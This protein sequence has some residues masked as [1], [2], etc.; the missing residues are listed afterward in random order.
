[1]GD[2]MSRTRSHTRIVSFLGLGRK[3]KP[4]RYDPVV[5]ELAIDGPKVSTRP[6]PMHDAATLLACEG[7]AS[8][9][10]LGTDVVREVWLDTGDSHSKAEAE[11]LDALLHTPREALKDVALAFSTLP[12]DVSPDN[13]WDLFDSV[14][15]AL[16]PQP[17]EADPS[18]LFDG[19]F[20]TAPPDRIILDITHGFRAQPFLAAAAVLYTQ[21]EVQRRGDTMPPVRILYAE[22]Q[23]A[24]DDGSEKDAPAKPTPVR[25][26]TRF[27]DIVAW[28]RAVDE[29]E[30]FGRGDALAALLERE[31][32]PL[33]AAG[34]AFGRLSRAL[35]SF[36]RDLNGLRLTNI[37]TQSAAWVRDMVPA[38]R[39]LAEREA[40]LLKSCFDRVERLAGE[41]VTTGDAPHS[42]D[43][44]RAATRLTQRYLSWSR[45]LEA[46]A[47]LRESMVTSAVLLASDVDPKASIRDVREGAKPPRAD[48][49]HPLQPAFDDLGQDRNDLLHCG[50]VNGRP[51]PGASVADR[52]D[53]HLQTFIRLP[54]STSGGEH[55]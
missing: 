42:T 25:D 39:E 32:R 53:H 14:V 26:L 35:E 41:L 33:R 22:F 12:A 29:L 7:P 28:N 44:L 4:R 30:R 55:V 2:G 52:V 8:L 50:F 9:L 45:H 54:H 11:L 51:L 5:Y 40:P 38:A 27:L 34:A 48:N 18:G 1:M 16:D 49:T 17:I 31:R 37:F 36:T 20:E 13:Q 24:K 10:W 43:A 3:D 15:R 21:A 23:S 47:V 19:P 6:T 46:I